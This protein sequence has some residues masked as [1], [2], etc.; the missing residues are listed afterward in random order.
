MTSSPLISVEALAAAIDDP[1]LR[2]V[3]V[4]WYLGKPGAGREGQSCPC[5]WGH[6]CSQVTNRCVKLCQTAAPEAVCTTGMCQ[7]SAELPPGWGV[8]VGSPRP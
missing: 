7:V 6:V 1:A 8:C 4:R 3:D 5:D 2:V